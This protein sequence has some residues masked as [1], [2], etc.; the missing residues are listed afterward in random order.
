TN[1]SQNQKSRHCHYCGR[2]RHLIAKCR[3]RQAEQKSRDDRKDDRRNNYRRDDYRRDERRRSCSRSRDRS[4]RSFSR[5]RRNS[6]ENF[7]ERSRYLDSYNDNSRRTGFRS[8][9]PYC[10]D[11]N[12]LGHDS[13]PSLASPVPSNNKWEHFLDNPSIRIA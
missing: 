9:S 2:T 8:L 3:T 11:I 6:R 7:R 10:R 12:Y 13:T 4:Y 5:D 1:T